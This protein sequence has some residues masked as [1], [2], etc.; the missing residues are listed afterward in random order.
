MK[1]A[2]GPAAV[3]VV[4]AIPPIPWSVILKL[5]AIGIG[6]VGLAAILGALT[7]QIDSVRLILVAFGSLASAFALSWRAGDWRSW[8]LAGAT[9]WVAVL[10]LPGHWDSIRLVASVLGGVALAAAVLSRLP[11]EWRYGLLSLAA[12][13]HFGGILA[14]TTWP[15]TYGRS[16]PWVTNQ[17]AQRVYLPYFKFCYMINAYHFYSPDPGPASHLYFLIEYEIDEPELDATGEPKIGAAGQ[18]IKKTTAEWVDIPRRRTDF[19]DPM[20]LTYNRRLSITELVSYSTPGQ[21][22]APSWEKGLA[23]QQRRNNELGLNGKPVPGATVGGE[24]ELSQYRVPNMGLRRSMYPSYARHIA[25]EYSGPRKQP[26]GKTIEYTVQS[27]KMFR[28]EHR[29]VE[30]NQFLE[31]PN[32]EAERNRQLNPEW[33]P[34]AEAMIG[35]ISP[36]HPSLYAP[37]YLGEYSAG[38]ELMKPDDPLLYWLIPVQYQQVK[39]RDDLGYID[40]MSKYAGREFV[41]SS[42]E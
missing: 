37:F 29:V 26:D 25:Q 33:R 5:F 4:D 2:I 14:A 22:T 20:G 40:W 6:A 31:Y 23:I 11:A 36:Y 9:A 42:K 15:D 3:P 27:V 24:I 35:K 18:P 38:G 28:V 41:W 39:N 8:V 34:S 13:F 30:P 32:P 1:S 16:A 17:A 21:A 12:L 7:S 19:R 10:G